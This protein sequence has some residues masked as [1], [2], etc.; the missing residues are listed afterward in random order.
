MLYNNYYV[1][2]SISGPKLR[3]HQK[4]DWIF[5]LDNPKSVFW[6]FNRFSKLDIDR[7]TWQNSAWS[8]Y[9]CLPTCLAGEIAAESGSL[10]ICLTVL[11]PS[12]H[13]KLFV[14]QSRLL[15][16]CLYGSTSNRFTTEI[17]QI[18]GKQ[19]TFLSESGGSGVGF[20]YRELIS[21]ESIWTS[22]FTNNHQRGEKGW[23]IIPN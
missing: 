5:K 13:P 7:V 12:W 4:F 14:G 6:F 18:L 9:L 10:Y 2:H 3:S 20:Q 21:Y 11:R 16:F 15:S 19:L 17:F 1:L 23:K 22:K 8:A